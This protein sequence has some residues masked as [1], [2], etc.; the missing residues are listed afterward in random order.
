M[1]S[2]IWEVCLLAFHSV[3]SE[4][5]IWFKSRHRGQ[6]EARIQVSALAGAQLCGKKK[7]TEDTEYFLIH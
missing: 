3:G 6:E 2:F 5:N 1:S 4:R 7:S